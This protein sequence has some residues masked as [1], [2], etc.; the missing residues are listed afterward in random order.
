MSEQTDRGEQGAK[1]AAFLR[2]KGLHWRD[3]DKALENHAQVALPVRLSRWTGL[4]CLSSNRSP[5]GPWQDLGPKGNVWGKDVGSGKDV[6]LKMKASRDHWEQLPERRDPA[7]KQNRRGADVEHQLLQAR[8]YFCCSKDSKLSQAHI[9]DVWG[10]YV[11]RPE[12]NPRP[13]LCGAHS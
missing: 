6:L 7:W 12:Q 13:A 8:H 3:L 4:A 10:K 2:G 11:A 1:D 9:R 5:I